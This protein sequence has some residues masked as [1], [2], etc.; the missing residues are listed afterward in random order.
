M[1]Y[2]SDID[3]DESKKLQQIIMNYLSDIDFDE[4]KSLYRN[5]T[6]SYLFLVIDI[7][8]PSECPLSF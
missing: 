6:K 4:F 7:A 1:S 5:L 2:L 3:F 8:F